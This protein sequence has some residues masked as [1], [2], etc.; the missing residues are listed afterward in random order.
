MKYTVV[1]TG[2]VERD[3][4]AWRVR[5]TGGTLRTIQKAFA[6][7]ESNTLRQYYQALSVV[8]TPP[9]TS[10]T[11]GEFTFPTTQVTAYVEAF[12]T[13]GVA[14]ITYAWVRLSG[15]TALSANLPTGKITNFVGNFPAAA[16]ITGVF[17][18]NATD[19]AG[20][21]ATATCA[22]SMTCIDYN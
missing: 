18:V 7:D 22:V 10:H 9:S 21:N 1:D 5:D 8:V 3:I 4:A 15:S 13:G 17:Q 16:T 2:S 20:S 19:A 6:R 12:P 11:Q 14:P